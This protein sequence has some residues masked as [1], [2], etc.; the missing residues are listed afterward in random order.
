[1]ERP[2]EL[3][4]LCQAGKLSEPGWYTVHRRISIYL[5][6][7]LLHTRV[8]PSQITVLMMVLG[9]AGA[10]LIASP[11]LAIDGI[12]FALLYLSFLLDKVDGEIARYRGVESP[13]V[14]LLDRFHHLAVEPA[15]M[16]SAAFRAYSATGS[17]VALVAGL[18][19]IVLGNII[20]EQGHLAPYALAKH[21]REARRLPRLPDKTAS[22]RWESAYRLFR[23][24]KMFRMF[25]AVLPA[26]ML[27]YGA[28]RV[29]GRPLVGAY[30]EG[31]AVALGV[32]L[33]FQT[34]YYHRVKFEAEMA[35]WASVIRPDAMGAAPDGVP[36]VAGT[37]RVS[38]AADRFRAAHEGR[39]SEPRTVSGAKRHE[40]LSG[41]VRDHA[42]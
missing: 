13:S 31:C 7:A 41:V 25:I 12:G 8:T 39:T 33:V 24:L 3:R 18:V 4:A 38:K 16:F 9:A 40:T 1:M 21:L 5:T 42:S 20:E 29:V 37:S 14:V 34:L 35:S 26:L 19:S 17:V 32:Y 11:R 22:G 36:L 10:M 15:I 23:T 27:I 28:E 2:R 6:W 30:L